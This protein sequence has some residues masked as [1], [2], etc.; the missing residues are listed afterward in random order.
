[1]R[2]LALDSFCWMIY[3][4]RTWDMNDLQ[5]VLAT[6]SGDSIQEWEVDA[7]GVIFE[8][9]GNFTGTSWRHHPPESLYS[10]RIFA[11]SLLENTKGFY[12]MAVVWP[13]WRSYTLSHGIPETDLS[14]K[15]LCNSGFRLPSFAMWCDL[16]TLHGAIGKGF[17]W[18]FRNPSA[19]HLQQIMVSPDRR[20]Q[21]FVR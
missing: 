2:E 16:S 15:L 14:R 20:H 9:C 10:P 4:I 1:M 5:V 3:T 8:A 13:E 7:P 17:Q 21:N 11:K 18:R 19:I 12:L 6:R